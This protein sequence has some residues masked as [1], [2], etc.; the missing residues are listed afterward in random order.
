VVVNQL[1]T[2]GQRT[3][4]GHY[5]FELLRCLRAQATAAEQIDCFPS[6]WLWQ[7]RRLWARAAP[8]PDRHEPGQACAAAPLSVAGKLKRMVRGALAGVGQALMA[9]HLQR[10]LGRQRC[11]LY[12]EPN[13]LP[14]DCDAP[15]L[16]TLCDL[17]VLLHP[18]W[19]PARRVA[20]FERDWPRALRQ[21]SHFLAISEFTR[22]EVLQHLGVA[23]ERV[24]TTYMGTRPGLRPL[25]T[26]AVAPV[27]RR[28]GLPPRYLLYLGT[29]EPR[30]NLMLLLRAYLAL[31]PGLR[32]E[33]PLL[34]V[35]NWGWNTAELAAYLDGEA[36]HRGVRHVG[37]LAEEHL[38]AV[39]NGARAL[40][41]PSLYEG[42]G[43][44]P[45][46]MLA[47]GGAVLASTAG[48][49]A[50]VAGGQA[51]LIDAHDLD[52]WRRALQ[53]VL[54]DDDWWRAL[55]RGAAE[56]ARPFTWERCAAQTLHVYRQLTGGS[57][58]LR[59]AA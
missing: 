1:S 7:A 49:V 50:E 43:L 53:R 3:G 37:Y 22:R 28:L 54:G 4:V 26:E 30:K 55:R 6:G 36:R 11:D 40:V 38:A 48:A 10:V 45:V 19:H 24:T 25:P 39:Y 44:P 15:T 17:S 46:E 13:H 59:Q 56:A 12:H 57:E 5:T 14:L 2:L 41:Y 42:F 21:T 32:L 9:R 18:E 16:T 34:L 35:G 29:L 20:A 33:Y 51:Q 58:L 52:G 23:P 27:L 31:D 8:A 47:C